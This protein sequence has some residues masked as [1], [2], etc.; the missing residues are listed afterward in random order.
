M[1]L[2]PAQIQPSAVKRTGR[3]FTVQMNSDL[4]H[5]K[6]TQELQKAKDI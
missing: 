3:L 1:A 5:P 6:T 4:K 2:L